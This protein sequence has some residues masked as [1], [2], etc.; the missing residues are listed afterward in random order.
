MLATILISRRAGRKAVIMF[1]ETA[2]LTPLDRQM[3][4]ILGTPPTPTRTAEDEADFQR[5]IKL[6]VDQEEYP[7]DLP[8]HVQREVNH[9]C[10]HVPGAALVYEILRRGF[11][12][13]LIAD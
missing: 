10:D 5:Q 11:A 2:P 9:F 8:A 1:T 7:E 12:R 13:G 4:A 6:W 3:Q